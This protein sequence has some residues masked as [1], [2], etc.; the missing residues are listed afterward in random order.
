[1]RLLASFV[2]IVVS[3]MLSDIGSA[4]V[5]GIVTGPRP[6]ARV[7]DETGTLSAADSA[8]IERLARSIRETTNADMMVVV[9]PTTAGEPHRRFATDLF[10]RWRLGDAARNDGL[11]LFVALA[12]RKSEIILGDGLD[13]P[14]QRSASQRIMDQV[15]VPHFRA[16]RPGRAILDGATRA[17]TDI[18]GVSAEQAAGGDTVP[19]P[20]AAAGAL[21]EKRPEPILV[22]LVEQASPAVAGPLSTTD[23]PFPAPT[24]PAQRWIPPSS[25]QRQPATPSDPVAMMI[26][27]G[28]GAATG[29]GG[30]AA[31]RSLY[32]YRRRNCPHCGTTMIQLSEGED[33]AQLDRGETVEERLGSVD[34]DVWT[35]PV[36]PGVEKVRWGA[37]FTRYAKCPRCRAITKLHTVSRLRSPTQLRE[38]LERIDERCLHCG[39]EQ[40]SERVIPRLPEPMRSSIDW[41]SRSSSLSPSSSGRSSGGHSS[42]GGAS[43]SW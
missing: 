40:T 10:N 20:A 38:G 37:I 2:A 15:M 17:V 35:C 16:G 31:V 26:L 7:I 36:C 42:G 11:L 6:R 5:P 13:S 12:D 18:V 29:V 39:W 28:G 1:M 14:G 30:I 27:V 9:I 8:E 43:G 34:Y 41:S 21:V 33:D 23:P 25:V 22:P 32:R 24:P 19:P 4:Q 3:L